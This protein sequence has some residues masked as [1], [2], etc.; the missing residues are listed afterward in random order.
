M[1]AGS[2][3]MTN[4]KGQDILYIS[5]KRVK[6]N[7]RTVKLRG[8]AQAL[9]SL[10]AKQIF[11]PT[12]MKIASPTKTLKMESVEDLNLKTAIGKLHIKALKTIDMEARNVSTY[13]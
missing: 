5:P 7:F 3:R 6:T 12:N 8:K 10:Q 13:F 2:I 11:S 1:Q 9:K 4:S